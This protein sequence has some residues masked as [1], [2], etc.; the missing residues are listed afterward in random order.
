[1]SISEVINS[2][3]REAYEQCVK[4]PEEMSL[5]EYAE[6]VCPFPLSDFQKE[7]IE[8]YEQKEKEALEQNKEFCVVM[9]GRMYLG[10][11]FID[12][13]VCEWQQQNQ[14]TEHRCSCGRL[15][16]RFSG[17]AEIKCPK[18]GKLNRIR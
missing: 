7:L 13:L 1:M 6:R 11:N 9:P 2:V 8:Q 14:L 15:L 16:G 4:Q 5:V 3:E 17:K 18:C 12:R 10:R